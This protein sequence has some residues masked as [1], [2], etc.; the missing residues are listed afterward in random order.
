MA[1][2][3]ELS[4]SQGKKPTTKTGSLTPELALEILQEAVIRCQQSGIKAGVRLYYGD[5]E[6]GI[7]VILIGVDM[8]GKNLVLADAG[9]KGVESG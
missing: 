4:Q 2:N 8:A 9:N 5:G 1:V 6:R 7:E 3:S